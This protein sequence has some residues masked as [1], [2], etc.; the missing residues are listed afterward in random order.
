MTIIIEH[1]LIITTLVYSIDDDLS[2]YAIRKKFDW[3]KWKELSEENNNYPAMT[4]HFKLQIRTLQNA[5]EISR[6]AS[7]VRSKNKEK[8]VNGSTFN[9]IAVMSAKSLLINILSALRT[10]LLVILAFFLF[11]PFY[12]ATNTKAYYRFLVLIT[13]LANSFSKTAL[14]DTVLRRAFKKSGADEFKRQVLF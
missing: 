4:N 6:V 2:E 12:Q 11:S 14:D 9:T 10:M 1:G 13:A 3:I 7:T 8:S 5:L